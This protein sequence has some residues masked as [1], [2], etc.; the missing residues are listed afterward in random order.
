[1]THNVQTPLDAG[2]DTQVDRIL[3]PDSTDLVSK[4]YDKKFCNLFSRIS[5][6]K[7]L[8]KYLRQNHP[9]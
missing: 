3:I 7:R 2:T 8:L 9:T 1:M 5:L 4:W 6:A